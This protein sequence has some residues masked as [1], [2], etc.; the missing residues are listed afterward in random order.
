METNKELLQEVLRQTKSNAIEQANFAGR[1]STFM[2]EQRDFNSTQVLFNTEVKGYLESNSKT[3]QK[4][5]VEQVEV[6]TGEIKG[7]KTNIETE[8]KVEKA[9][10]T[11]IG[12]VVGAILTF[13]G[14]V[15]F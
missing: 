12:I 1:V 6:N 3:N 5:L 9:K 10:Q 13:L 15:F 14:K 11:I 4:G 8:K 2:N 7:I